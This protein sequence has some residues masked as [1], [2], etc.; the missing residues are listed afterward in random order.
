MKPDIREDNG[1]RYLS[2]EI[3]G[4]GYRLA[5]FPLSEVHKAIEASPKV[6]VY[7]GGEVGPFE[8]PTRDISLIALILT[9]DDDSVDVAEAIKLEEECRD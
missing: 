9:A 3:Y 6:S 2:Y 5:R 1:T 4:D 7:V 8:L